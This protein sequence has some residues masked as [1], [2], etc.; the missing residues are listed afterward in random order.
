MYFMFRM[1][2]DEVFG[3]DCGEECVQWME[4]ALGRK[5]RLLYNASF[6]IARSSFIS[7]VHKFPLLRPDD[8]VSQDY[9]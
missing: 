6:P 9:I 1:W 3:L 8:E 5:C 2:D 7:E 4:E